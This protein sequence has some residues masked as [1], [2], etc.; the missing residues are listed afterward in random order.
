MTVLNLWC[1]PRTVS[2]ALMYSWRQRADA[3]VLDEPFYGIYLRA[4]DPGH[5][6]RDEILAAMPEDVD[7]VVARIRAEDGQRPVRF[8]KNIGHHLDALPGSILDEFTN[9][10]LVRDPARVIAS[11]DATLHADFPATIT[12]LPQQ[13]RILDHELEAGRRPIVIDAHRLLADP[14]GVLAAL[15]QAVGLDFD[16]AMLQWPPGPKPEDGVWAKHW[17]AA[18][19]RSTSFG[20][21]PTTE[22]TLT[23]SQQRLLEECRPLY[24]QLV[25]HHLG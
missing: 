7:T 8:V 16:E 10:I 11:L 23:E 3:R 17:Y 25:G 9:A 12:G 19:H 24:E 15:C 6:G 1:G 18:A 13:V 20:P 14:P 22:A 21:P 2:T 4:F 5:P